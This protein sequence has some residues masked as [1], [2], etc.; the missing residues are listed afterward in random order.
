MNTTLRSELYKMYRCPTL[1]V[2]IIVGCGISFITFYYAYAW[3]R[4]FFNVAPY[5]TSYEGLSLVQY[6]IGGDNISMG[7]TIFYTVLPMLSTIPYCWSYWNERQSHYVNHLLI[8]IPK[9]VYLLTKFFVVFLSGAIAVLIPMFLNLIMTAWVM[10]SITPS[11]LLLSPPTDGEFLSRLFYKNTLFYIVF[12]FVVE[13]LWGG[14]LACVG[15]TASTF[16]HSALG[17]VLAPFIIFIGG[18]F[19]QIS[20]TSSVNSY[21]VEQLET[22]PLLL[23]QPWASACAPLWY[24]VIV[25]VSLFLLAYVFYL[26]WGNK[27]EML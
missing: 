26:M 10:P 17:A 2:S 25:I 8:R 21:S 22:N 19:I 18:S 5:G 12:V 27:D 23:L 20:I 15:L 14:T 13:F 3:K 6:W 7:N 24:V 16:M 11:V 1:W 9:K 4:E